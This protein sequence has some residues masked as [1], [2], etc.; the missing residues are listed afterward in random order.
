M[1]NHHAASKA[2]LAIRARLA[3]YSKARD[4]HDWRSMSAFF[5]PNADL[6]GSTGRIS[7]D[8]DQIARN[9]QR[10]HDTVYRSSTARRDI[11]TIRFLR[12][13]VAIV[14][15]V[16]EVRGALGADGTSLESIKGRFTYVLT[17]ER[18]EWLISAYRSM[19]PANV[20]G[21]Q[22]REPQATD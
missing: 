1:T 9:F 19:I 20:F 8:R 4:L 17:Q 21:D 13:D 10:E 11:D 15:G 18:G 16:F 14:D 3:S 2:K 12:E 7:R 22:P 6:I 5:T